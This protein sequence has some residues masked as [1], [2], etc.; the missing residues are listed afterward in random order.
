MCIDE[1]REK[2]PV[3]EIYE[4]GNFILHYADIPSSN[5]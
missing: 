4:D 3:K 2:V 1:D 5:I